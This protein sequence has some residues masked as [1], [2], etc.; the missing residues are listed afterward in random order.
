MER[1]DFACT[2]CYLGPEA[3]ETEPLAF[4]EVREQLDA[5]RAHL[6][7][8]GKTQITAGEVTLLP[9]DEL[10][11][12][13]AYALEIGLDPMVMSHGQ[14]F[15]EEPAYLETLVRDYGLR[16]I[17]VH[18]DT[19][20]RGRRGVPR[21]VG[22]GELSSVRSDFADLIRRT[23]RRTGRP[24]SAASTI[25]VTED[26]VD[27]MAKVL[28]WFALNADAFRL[29]SFQPVAMVG[30]TRNRHAGESVED[31]LWR[32]IK[33]VFGEELNE[34]PLHF[35]HP[36]CNV[37][38]PLAIA[39]LGEE[40]EVFEAALK[41]CA[42][43]REFVKR[44]VEVLGNRVDWSA[45]KANQVMQLAWAFARDFGYAF[46]L[47]A[48]CFRRLLCERKK[49]FR[50]LGTMLRSLRAPKAHPF[51]IVIHS[52]MDAKELQSEKGKERLDACVFKLP[53]EG[54][55]V[56]MCE[57]NASDIRKRIDARLKQSKAAR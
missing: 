38:V 8:G 23:R 30:R 34:R 35:G 1:C 29:L 43:D 41:G 9:V 39:R 45:G 7:V 42:R 52:F 20:Q 50:L 33:R 27:E 26:N 24:L 4:E 28:Q 36:D 16:K 19:T 21:G 46:S 54:A 5:L 25:T 31:R 40:W 17:S 51:L 48:F 53:V 49:V 12:I 18:V 11:R 6:G 2:C 22:E 15:L 10:G 37:T 44:S 13:V 56:S 55:M 57:M 3:N 32:Q 47:L 14:R